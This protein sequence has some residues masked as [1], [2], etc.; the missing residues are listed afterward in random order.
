M[1]PK[2]QST[3]IPTGPAAASTSSYSAPVARRK[4]KDLFSFITG[5][6]FTLSILLALGVFGYKYFLNYRITEMGTELEN[7]RA[8]LQPEAV[9]EL[10]RLNSRLVSTKSLIENHRII[11]PVF[12]FLEA[13]TPQS[14]RYTDFNFNMTPRGLDLRLRGEA[15]SYAALAAAA[16]VFNRASSNFRNP[17]FSDLQLDQRGN[18]IFSLQLEVEPEL[19]SYERVVEGATLTPTAILPVATTTPINATSSGALPR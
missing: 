9:A 19:L 4:Q 6:L 5:M 1:P 2:F 12:D 3:F 8:T 14:V 11:T 18:V 16:E 10:I 15:Q 17:T 13:A 7:A